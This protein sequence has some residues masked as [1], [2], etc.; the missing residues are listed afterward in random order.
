MLAPGTITTGKQ[1][2]CDDTGTLFWGDREGRRV[3]CARID[4]SGLADLVV[5]TA[6]GVLAE[7]VGVAVDR[8]RG[9]LYWSQKGPAKG[10][11]GRI[12]RAG[13]AIPAEET[14]ATRSDVE[15]LWDGLP[16]PID[17]HIDGR[18][19]YWSDRGAPLAG[20]RSTGHRCR[21]PGKPAPSR[22]SSAVASPRRSDWSWTR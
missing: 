20:T 4:G 19:L 3:S 11:Q 1:L 17:L 5:N 22:R 12:F 2:T 15:L 14:A 9:H 16:E 10:G 13:L 6:E 8:E 7:C 18:W 21:L